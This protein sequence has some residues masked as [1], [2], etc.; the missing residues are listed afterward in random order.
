MSKS[1]QKQ[2]QQTNSNNAINKTRRK[3]TKN[4]ETE[5]S[6]DLV[7]TFKEILELKD[8]QGKICFETITKKPERNRFITY[9]WYVILFDQ[10]LFFNYRK[11]LPI[12][13][14]FVVPVFLGGETPWMIRRNNTT[15][16][17][18][19]PDVLHVMVGVLLRACYQYDISIDDLIRRMKSDRD[20]P[21]DLDCYQEIVETIKRVSKNS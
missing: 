4:Q 1:K 9:L 7:D 3:L 16:W 12:L 17:S 21:V 6:T 10:T 8:H 5:K 11:K 15:G 18:L 14:G 2:V 19:D 20:N 13:D